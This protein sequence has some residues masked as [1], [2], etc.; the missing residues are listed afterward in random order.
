MPDTAPRIVPMLVYEDAPAAI[1]FLCRAFGFEERYRMPMPDG[2]LGHAELA[3]QGALV[4]LSSEYP[5]MGLASP[6][7]LPVLHCQIRCLVDDVDAHYQRAKQ[8]GAVVTA[9]PE[10]QEYGERM[11]RAVDPEGTRWIFA[12]PLA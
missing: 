6:K 5:E 11:Y 4:T 7:K 2:R 3:Y 12:A 1:E 10:D 8:A 9:E